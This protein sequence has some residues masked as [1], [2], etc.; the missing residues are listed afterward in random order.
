MII[1]ISTTEI[2]G[3]YA[4][5][6]KYKFFNK[7]S[8]VSSDI[9]SGKNYRFPAV[10]QAADELYKKEDYV[11][12]ANGYIALTI[13][14]ALSTE[15]RARA[16]FRLGIC[17]YKLKNYQLAFESFVKSAGFDINNS[18][19][20]N[21]A[22]VSAYRANDM[23]NAI[24]YEIKALK[25]RPAVEYYYNLARMYEDNEQY[26]LAVENYLAVATA[27]QNLTKIDKI[28]PVRVKE[29]VARLMSNSQNTVADNMVIGLRLNDA[30]NEVLTINE[31]EMQIKPGDFIVKVENQKGTKNIVAEYDRK[32]Y[33]PYNL[34]SEIGWTVYKNGRQVYKKV[35]DKINVSAIESGNYEVK[36]DIK[37]GGD[38]VKTSSKNVRINNNQ[39]TIDKGKSDEIIVS[40]PDD[41]YTK[42]YVQ[43]L[44][45][46][47]FE[48]DFN[49]SNKSYTDMYNVVWGM[50]NGVQ[51]Q[52]NKKLKMDKNSSLVVANSSDKDAGLW[53]NLDSLLKEERIKGKSIN[54]SFYARKVTSDADLYISV[55]VKSN[56]M[57][58]TSTE[59]F[60]T[61]FQ[62]EQKSVRVYIPE[63]AT[64]FTISIKTKP[65]EEFNID[66]FT[67]VD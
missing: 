39:S 13:N 49:I 35:S 19:I 66:G 51:T 8:P 12:A 27:E 50:D 60:S 22:A 43:A 16:H 24:E 18:V 10:M 7:T 20:Y 4:D 29:K 67:L 52:T 41:K 17:Q 15:Q 30:A 57:I 54:I 65:S 56:N 53:I 61:E 31:N 28:D 44:Y 25:L 48:S 63:D 55:R 45:E 42:T 11:G 64:G 21:N 37:Y 5:I 47:L 2:R 32:K 58:A 62:F 9:Q 46:Q 1:F 38:K 26:D 59:T 36:L 40:Q 6:I 14:S 3:R 34:I 23:K 33:D